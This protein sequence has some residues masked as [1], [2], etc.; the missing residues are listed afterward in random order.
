MQQTKTYQPDWRP[1]SVIKAE[2]R[3]LRSKA[4]RKATRTRKTRRPFVTQKQHR[5]RV[6]DRASYWKYLQTRHW[7]QVR[8][9][10]REQRLFCQGCGLGR[11]MVQLQVHHI[12]YRH[13]WEESLD[14]L[15]MLC[16]DCH[17]IEHFGVG[18]TSLEQQHLDSILVFP[19]QGGMGSVKGRASP[20]MR[21][22][23]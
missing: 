15:K 4:K 14:D 7:K 1:I 13:L 2:R 9:W 8:A 19:S 5:F 3:A 21:R 22:V 11:R 12:N 10:V 20:A 18:E 6:T 16:R 17:R 23:N